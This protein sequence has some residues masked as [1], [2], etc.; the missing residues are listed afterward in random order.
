MDEDHSS[1][2]VLHIPHSSRVVPEDARARI[3]LSDDELDQELLHLTDGYTDEIFDIDSHITGRVV[4]GLSRIVVDPERFLHDDY[5]PMSGFGMGAVYTK[6]TDGRTLRT[7]D[8]DYRD[9]LIDSYYKPH[10]DALTRAVDEAVNRHGF[11]FIIDCHS[12]PS[13]PLPCEIDQSP[14]RPDICIG[15]DDFHTPTEIAE[16]AVRLFCEAGYKTEINRPFG[17]AI[18]PMDYFGNDKRVVALMVEINRALYMDEET[19]GK[20]ATFDG[21]TAGIKRIVLELISDVRHYWDGIESK[22]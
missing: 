7:V 17:G 12:F 9:E 16:M 5:E 21:F 2:T 15:T 1:F 14:D 13:K 8:D 3:A 10:H 20:L 6:T 18:V 22:P 4:F 11:C 19:G